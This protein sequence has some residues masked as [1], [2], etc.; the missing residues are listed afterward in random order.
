[1]SFISFAVVV[2]LAKALPS[3]GRDSV[4]SS[5]TSRT[6]NGVGIL[7]PKSIYSAG[8]RTYGVDSIKF[9]CARVV[10]LAK[11]L[12]SNR[13]DFVGSSPTSGTKVM[14][15]CEHCGFVGEYI[16]H[17]CDPPLK[18]S[19]DGKYVFV[20]MSFPRAVI[21][22]EEIKNRRFNSAGMA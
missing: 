22:L 21:D 4:G 9:S 16:T 8:A 17:F 10:K 19:P 7:R 15:T 2:K 5:P 13:R 11:A 12:R 3:D 20:D 14:K 18:T 1:V 6:R